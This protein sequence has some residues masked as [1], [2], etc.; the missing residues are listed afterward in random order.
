MSK[1]LFKNLNILCKEKALNEKDSHNNI[2]NISILY[3]CS[4]TELSLLRLLIVVSVA[5]LMVIE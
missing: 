3:L 2:Y 4:M 1:A 5:A